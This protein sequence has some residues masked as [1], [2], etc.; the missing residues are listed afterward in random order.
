MKENKLIFCACGCGQR[1]PQYDRQGRERR[2][3]HAHHPPA[4]RYTKDSVLRVLRIHG[5]QT[6]T[7][8]AKHIGG[9]MTPERVAACLSRLQEQGNV[10]QVGRH[11]WTMLWR[12]REREYGTGGTGYPR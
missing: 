4:R 10:Q 12:E 9:G 7:D 8:I 5:P 2:Y 3:V 6:R 1:L 11:Q